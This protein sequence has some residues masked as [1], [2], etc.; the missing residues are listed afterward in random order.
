MQKKEKVGTK[1]TIYLIWIQRPTAN[2][3]KASA[4]LYSIVATAQANGIDTERYL[5]DLFSHPAGT[6]ILPF[7]T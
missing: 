5:T 6:I 3:A 1:P 2:G 7:P 4:V